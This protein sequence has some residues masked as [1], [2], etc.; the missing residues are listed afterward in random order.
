LTAATLFIGI[1]SRGL[2]SELVERRNKLHCSMIQ[3]NEHEIWKLCFKINRLLTSTK[4]IEGI[5]KSTL[6]IICQVERS[7]SKRTV[8]GQA[9]TYISVV[10]MC[11]LEFELGIS[12]KHNIATYIMGGRAMASQVYSEA[13]ARLH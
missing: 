5:A 9:A 6:P 4:F 8:A 11:E 7:W 2:R 1:F 12:V 10:T 13:V 3:Y